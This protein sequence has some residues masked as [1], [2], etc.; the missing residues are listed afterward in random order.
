[1]ISQR[2][3]EMR[4]RRMDAAKLFAQD[5]K[6]A[7]IARRLQVSRQSVSRWQQSWTKKGKQGLHGSDRTGRPHKLTVVELKKIAESLLKGPRAN[8]MDADLWTLSR[9]RK[10]IESITGKH[11][12]L[13][14]VWNVLRRLGWS[15]Q[16]P[17]KRA[18]QRNE[19]A[20]AAWLKRTWPAVK[21]TPD[22]NRP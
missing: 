13:S 12:T 14:G 6:P 15:A 2:I 3:T 21:K 8:G 10:L 1:M 11:F 22:G 20:V 7:E 9:M 19:Q 16:R 18:L 4:Q 5:V 17:A